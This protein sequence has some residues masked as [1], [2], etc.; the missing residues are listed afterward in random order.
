MAK[1][2][3]DKAK[4]KAKPAKDDVS[5]HIGHRVSAGKHPKAKDDSDVE[6][7]IGHRVSAGKHPK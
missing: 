7:H 5:G 4:S 6:G 1:D 3:K 2:S